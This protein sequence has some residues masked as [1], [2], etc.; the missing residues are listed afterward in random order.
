VL[1]FVPIY[2][3][4]VAVFG[5]AALWTEGRSRLARGFLLAGGSPS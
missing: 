5:F 1:R 3:V 4:G 2:V